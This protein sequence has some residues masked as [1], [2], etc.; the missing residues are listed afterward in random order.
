MTA[1]QAI[2]ENLCLFWQSSGLGCNYSRWSV[3]TVSF[4]LLNLLLQLV[5]AIFY[6]VF[7]F[8]SNDTLQKLWKMF[9]IL[10]KK[11]F[12]F[13]RYSN[14]CNF[15]SSFLLFPDSKGQMEVESFM[16]SSIG[17]HKFTG[18]IFGIAQKLFYITPSNLAR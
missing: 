5:C 12:S 8:S 16:M 11:L 7:I 9:F 3:G 2:K 14:F 13:S 15:S 6:Q 17:L 10:P 1:K 4:L 18:V